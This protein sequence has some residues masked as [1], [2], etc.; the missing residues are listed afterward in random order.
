M[1]KH[2][3]IALPNRPGEFY[4]VTSLLSNAGI[5]ILALTLVAHGRSGSAHMLCSPHQAA[6]QMLF[7][8]YKFYCSEKEVVVVSLEHRVGAVQEV[9]EVLSQAEINLPNC[10]LGLTDAKDALVV[11]EFD[12][13]NSCEM[14]QQEL[15]N[16][17]FALFNSE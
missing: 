9:F 2:I 16:G 8:E 13:P 12:T 4:N 17:E 14:A 10:Y 3:T 5:N 11:L 15:K 6:F 1:C 7:S